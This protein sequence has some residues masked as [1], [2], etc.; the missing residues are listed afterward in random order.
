MEKEESEGRKQ[1]DMKQVDESFVDPTEVKELL[2]LGD[3]E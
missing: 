2:E 1:Q 3:R